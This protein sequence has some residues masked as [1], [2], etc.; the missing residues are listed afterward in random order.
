MNPKWAVRE[1]EPLSD[2][3]LLLT[4]ED[5]QKKIVDIKGF[6][7]YPVF[8]PLKNEA[9]FRTV[10]VEA[11]TAVWSDQIDMDPEFLYAE[12]QPVP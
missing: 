10:H 12:G 9:F 3:R 6:L 2:Y 8:K 11:C 1:V 7:D 4:F 5:R